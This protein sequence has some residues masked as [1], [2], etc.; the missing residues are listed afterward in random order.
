M[1]ALSNV[2][3]IILKCVHLCEYMSGIKYNK[4]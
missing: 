1:I 2:D 3:K 4:A